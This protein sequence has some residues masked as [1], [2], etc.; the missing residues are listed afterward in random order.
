MIKN[1][2]LST[3]LTMAITLITVFC[4]SLLF[5]IAN[6]NMTDAMKTTAM[7]NMKTSIEA[8]TKIIEEYVKN[9]EEL[10]IAYSKAPAIAALLKEPENKELQKIAQDYTQNYYAG[11]DQW[12]GIYTGEWNSHVITHANPDVVGMTTREG[13]G[14]KQ[15]QDAITNSNGIYNSGIIVSPASKKLILSMYCPVF[16]SDGK[17]ILGYVG[18]GP[19]AEG[20][21]AMLDSLV[22]E[23]LENAKYTMINTET[24]VYIFNEDES[25]MSQKIED[26]MLLSAIDKIHNAS[27]KSYNDY[28]Y[29]DSKGE[30]SVAM[31]E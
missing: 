5:V 20:L 22:T 14:L 26:K 8:K 17:T 16:D 3:I 6:R 10:L 13:E 31:Y 4:I 9:S 24:G 21:K 11:L 12:E 23:G 19:F 28:D 2:K 15:L 7:N 30:K 27:D 25:L 29:I 1:R 18:G